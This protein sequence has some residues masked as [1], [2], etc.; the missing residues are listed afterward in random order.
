MNRS[1]ILFWSLIAVAVA[2]V[3]A[4]FAVP[5]EAAPCHVKVQ[6]VV[7][8]AYAYPLVQ[9][10][11]YSVGESAR[12]EAVVE[13]K[14]Q[15]REKQ[16]RSMANGQP[17]APEAADGSPALLIKQ[18]CA[19]CHGGANAKGGIRLDGS[20]AVSDEAFRSFSR[21][22]LTGDGIPKA[23]QPLMQ[24]LTADEGSAILGELLR[25]EA[26]KQS[27]GEEGTLK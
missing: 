6:R 3:F 17:V 18:K 12:F 20:E 9:P 8:Y 7:N 25:L 10:I 23:M 15:E 5:V 1:D 27:P 11:Y 19:A 21:M 24:K 22:Y 2:L 13:K 14:L 4:L 26:V 16:W